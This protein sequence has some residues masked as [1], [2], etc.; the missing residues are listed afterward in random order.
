MPR[1]PTLTFEGIRTLLNRVNPATGT[2]W[3]EAEIAR[4]HGLTRQAVS[5]MLHSGDDEPSLRKLVTDALPW[6][7]L[8]AKQNQTETC[9]NMRLHLRY[10]LND[11]RDRVSTAQLRRLYGFY[12]KLYYGDLVVKFDPTDP[13]T[14]EG[15]SLVPRNADDGKLMV[16]VNEYTTLTEHGKRL[17]RIPSVWPG[18]RRTN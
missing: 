16:R 9:R 15:F 4:A 12:H 10:R 6:R 18:T 11:P 1:Q 5:K 3:T 2:W 14:T 13:D 8:T 7:G 17:L